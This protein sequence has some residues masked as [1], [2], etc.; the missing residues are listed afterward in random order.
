[1]VQH[2]TRLQAT[3][4]PPHLS[5]PKH[6]VLY[7]LIPHCFFP[8]YFFFLHL[9]HLHNRYEFHASV[10]QCLAFFFSISCFAWSLACCKRSTFL[11]LAASMILLA[12]FSASSIFLISGLDS[13]IV[14]FTIFTRDKTFFKLRIYIQLT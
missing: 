4:Q 13:A 11:F 5:F 12:S 8:Q 2:S 3:S 1:M 14:C 9:N 7:E 10:F 6:F